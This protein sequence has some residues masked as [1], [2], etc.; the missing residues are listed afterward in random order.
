M[1]SLLLFNNLCR[2]TV[3]NICTIECMMKS[4]PSSLPPARR[5]HSNGIMHSLLL[6]Q[7]IIIPVVPK[8]RMSNW[9]SS[10]IRNYPIK[11]FLVI[12]IVR[13][14]HTSLNCTNIDLMCCQNNYKDGSQL[15]W[16]VQR[17]LWS[18]LDPLNPN[19]TF[20]EITNATI[21]DKDNKEKVFKG[22][23]TIN[24]WR[25]HFILYCCPKYTAS[26]EF[27]TLW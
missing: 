27:R 15:Q 25:N 9:K 17:I 7:L 19:S 5:N 1:F 14:I 13:T 10:G 20:N 12:I 22:F 24:C 21:F 23:S 18:I 26:A 4:L 16:Y 8:W 11:D 6:S 3:F 2:S